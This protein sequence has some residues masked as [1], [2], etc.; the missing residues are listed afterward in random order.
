MRSYRILLAASALL[1]ACATPPKQTDAGMVAYDKDT[2][3]AVTARPGRFCL[4]HQ[5]L[6][7]S[8]HSGK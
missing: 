8:V 1:A 5:L 4:G 3:Y 6:A 7:L 2:E